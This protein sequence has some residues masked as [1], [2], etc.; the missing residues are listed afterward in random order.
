M[1]QRS[2]T[3]QRVINTDIVKRV[4]RKETQR[5]AGERREKRQSKLLFRKRNVSTAVEREEREKKRAGNELFEM[6][7]YV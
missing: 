6:A 2:V 3:G 5:A 7:R 1:I 4:T